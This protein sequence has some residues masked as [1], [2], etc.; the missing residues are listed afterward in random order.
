MPICLRKSFVVTLV[1]SFAGGRYKRFQISDTE[2]FILT[3][4]ALFVDNGNNVYSLNVKCPV[5]SLTFYMPI[6]ALLL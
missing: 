5:R 1:C 4:L 6:G 3:L 2:I